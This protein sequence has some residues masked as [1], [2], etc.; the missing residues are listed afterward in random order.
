MKNT[1]KQDKGV[2]GLTILLS[3]IVML[4]VIGL[5]VMI[6]SI[7]GNKLMNTQYDITS[8]TSV[9]ETLAKPTTAGITLTTGYNE[10]HGVC[11]ALTSVINQST[12]TNVT[13]GAGNYSQTGCLITNLTNWANYSTNVWYSYPYT[14]DKNN[15]ATG[16]MEGTITAISGTVNWFGI[17][18]TIGSMVVLILL[19]V[20]IIAA[21][22][23]SGMVEGGTVSSGAGSTNGANKVGTA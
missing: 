3:L 1:F 4:F 16:V 22:K 12:T 15:T 23:G 21:I 5:L 18:I 13:I 14:Y 10:L 8:A 9:N 20:I 11:G 6:F 7:M 19:V 17:F 2:A